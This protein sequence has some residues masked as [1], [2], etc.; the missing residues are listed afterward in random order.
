MDA[1][2]L[3]QAIA[4]ALDARARI[5]ELEHRA[6]HDW[7]R[8]QIDKGKARREFWSAVMQKSL[9]AIAWT[10]LSAAAVGAWNL[11]KG[12]ISWN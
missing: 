10:L 7:V 6:H 5:P 3:K 4:E 9:P 1:D 12:H 11:L 8:E 2:Q